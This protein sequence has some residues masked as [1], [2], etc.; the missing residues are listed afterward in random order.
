[1]VSEIK[2]IN[3]VVTNEPVKYEKEPVEVQ[4]F[5]NITDRFE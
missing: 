2:Y 3:G 1:M 5:R 4:D